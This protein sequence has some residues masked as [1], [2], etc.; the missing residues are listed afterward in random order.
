MVDRVV[1]D[2]GVDLCARAVTGTLRF[3]LRPIVIVF[4]WSR[5]LRVASSV[6]TEGG[7]APSPSVLGTPSKFPRCPSLPDMID[8]FG[9][10]P[11]LAHAWRRAD[12]CL[13]EP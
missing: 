10:Y 6:R 13:V 11:D 2:F 3:L 12:I 7:E 4:K 9:L 1:N 5:C 8:H